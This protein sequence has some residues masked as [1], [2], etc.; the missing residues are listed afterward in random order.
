MILRRHM[1]FHAS[2]CLPEQLILI[3]LGQCCGFLPASLFGCVAGA[4]A[5][6]KRGE[7]VHPNP[8]ELIWLFSK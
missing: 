6:G 5:E 2:S 1:P 3:N 8:K 7:L 4:K